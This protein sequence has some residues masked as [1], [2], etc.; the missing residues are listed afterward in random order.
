MKDK[1]INNSNDI[2][3]ENL[4]TSIVD[5]LFNRCDEKKK[6]TYL[7]SSKELLKTAKILSTQQ[8]E[9]IFKSRARYYAGLR[10]VQ[11]TLKCVVIYIS[12]QLAIKFPCK[13]NGRW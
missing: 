11:T 6:N 8:V 2:L 13:P 12:P 10:A 5:G 9:G 4:E 3:D 1:K 7:G